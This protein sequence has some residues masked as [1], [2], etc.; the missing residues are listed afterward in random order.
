MKKTTTLIVFLLLLGSQAIANGLSEL[1]RLKTKYSLT[2]KV[3]IDRQLVSNYFSNTV[4]I[5]N[6]S[7]G[8]HSLQVFHIVNSYYAYSEEV[9]FIGEVFLPQNTLTKA[10]IKNNNFIIVHQSALFNRKRTVNYI[11]VFP[12]Y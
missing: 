12:N 5:K 7:S 8:N 3:L 2:I 4:E 1:L 10:I 11:T 9:L 6:I